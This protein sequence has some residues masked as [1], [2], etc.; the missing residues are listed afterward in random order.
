M[1][2]SFYDIKDEEDTKREESDFLYNCFMC[3]N[4]GV[5]DTA[6]KEIRDLTYAEFPQ[7]S[8][9]LKTML[10]RAI[11]DNCRIAKHGALLFG[12]Y[13]TPKYT[14]K[15][16]RESRVDPLKFRY[17]IQQHLAP[18]CQQHLNGEEKMDSLQAFVEEAR[19][20]YIIL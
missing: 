18:M 2:R 13:L 8:K 1:Q 11:K 16:I 10:D 5:I 12:L 14:D 9:R 7:V 3:K 6:L 17:Y 20:R 4:T 19:T 15:L